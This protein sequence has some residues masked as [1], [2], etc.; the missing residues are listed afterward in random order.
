MSGLGNKEIF[1]K[2]LRYYMDKKGVD[3]NQVCAALG[4]VYSTFT[5][6]YNGVKYPRIDKIEMLARYFGIMKSDLIE[7]HDHE[8][9][10][11]RLIENAKVALFDGGGEVTDAMWEEVLNF[12]HYVETREAAK[13]DENK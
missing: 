8:A 7:E 9:E 2:N 13:R 11:Q 12:A 4:F 3:R 1:S 10:R 5:D 6:W